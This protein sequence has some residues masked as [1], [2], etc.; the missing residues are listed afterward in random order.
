MAD[1]EGVSVL[2]GV[3]LLLHA[4]PGRSPDQHWSGGTD[5]LACERLALAGI[6]A[7]ARII[8]A[9]SVSW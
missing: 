3:L 2:P 4:L 8:T 9:E 5:W 7:P 1:G 6:P